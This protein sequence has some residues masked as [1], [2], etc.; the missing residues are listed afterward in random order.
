[1]KHS[2]SLVVGLSVVWLA[3]S[4]FVP[5]G[6][7]WVGLGWVVLALFIAQLLSRRSGRSIHDVI[8]AIERE[9]ALARAPK[10]RA[11]AARL[12]MCA[13]WLSAWPA[14]VSADVPD[15]AVELSA[16]RHGWS[17]CDRG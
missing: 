8:H 4:I 15:A 6:F 11:T 1:M 12:L 16:C 10:P 9:P 14:L 2:V 13:A 5:Y 17:P 3:C 7:P